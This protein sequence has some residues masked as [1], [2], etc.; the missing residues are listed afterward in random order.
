MYGPQTMLIKFHFVDLWTCCSCSYLSNKTLATFL[1]FLIPY[2]QPNAPVTQLW[3][4]LYTC[5]FP[6]FKIGI[7]YMQGWTATARHGVTKKRRTK[8]LK[9]AGSLFTESIPFCQPQPHV[10]IKFHSFY[11][12]FW[13]THLPWNK[14]RGTMLHN[15]I[16]LSCRGETFKWPKKKLLIKF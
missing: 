12:N 6:F 9:Y 15:I 1:P 8:R 13:R 5:F 4:P 10:H 14:D 7:H 3:C 11:A 2:L 16:S